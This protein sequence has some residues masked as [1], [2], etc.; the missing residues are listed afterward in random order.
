LPNLDFN[1]PDEYETAGVL[2]KPLR[3]LFS[4]IFFIF[5]I[6]LYLVYNFIEHA[7]TL[8]MIIIVFPLILMIAGIVI[9]LSINISRDR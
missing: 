5:I 4:F 6:F 2:Q 8:I 3:R 9:G 1:S 7:R